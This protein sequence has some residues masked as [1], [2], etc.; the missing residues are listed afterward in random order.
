[1]PMRFGRTRQQ[2]SLGSLEIGMQETHLV[3][4]SIGLAQIFPPEAI[5]IGLVQRTKRGVIEELVH[6]LVELGNLVQGEEKA[7]VE[8]VLA[9]EKLGS[10]AL[11]NGI[12]FPHCRWSPMEKLIGV[13]GLDSRGIPFDA[14]DG[15]P[16]H[17]VFLLMVPL[18]DRDNHYEVL[19]RITAIGRDKSVRLQLRG[20]RTAE[21]AHEFLQKLGGR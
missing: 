18:N 8:S 6:H 13:L 1:M 3:S 10:S 21:A 5:V 15:E 11:G 20:C 4:P 9:R 14:V 2:K 16:V 12:A 17:C 7:V 19:G